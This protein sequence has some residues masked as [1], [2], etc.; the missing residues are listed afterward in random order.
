[1]TQ[2]TLLDLYDPDRSKEVLLRGQQSSWGEFQKGFA[3]RRIEQL[4][5]RGHLLPLGDDYVTHSGGAVES[6]FRR[7]IRRPSCVQ[8]E[9]VNR[10][11]A[12]AASKAAFGSYMDAQYKLE[13][14]D[15]IFRWMRTS[16]AALRIRDSC[17]WR[18]RMRSGHRY[19]EGKT[20]NRLYVVESGASGDRFKADHRLA[21]KA[22]RAGGV[23]GGPVA[24][25]IGTGPYRRSA[26]ILRR[27]CWRT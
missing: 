20:M 16:W 6:R 2:A 22:E 17:R 14:A 9:P 11:S 12:M 23:R 21:L 18:R 27:R 7:S 19:E 5:G 13:N 1:L 3:A 15:V 4:H 25:G 10:D 24:N 26:E 8:W